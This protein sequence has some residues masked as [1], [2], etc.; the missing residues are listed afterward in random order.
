MRLVSWTWFLYVMVG[1][2]MGG[3]VSLIIYMLK[4]K[5]LKLKWYE[6]AGITFNF[7]LFMFMMQ[8]FIASFAE[9]A[10]RAAW[11]SLIFMGLPIIII[12]V[13]VY[14]SISKRLA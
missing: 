8:T 12:S 1:F 14:R 9:F 6:C 5:A 2:I 4:Q 11:L 7:I 10:P 3:G 13:V